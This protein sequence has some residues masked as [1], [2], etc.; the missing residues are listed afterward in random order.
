M[1]K[2]LKDQRARLVQFGTQSYEELDGVVD[3][4]AEPVQFGIKSLP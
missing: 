2:G 3:R 1:A 4:R